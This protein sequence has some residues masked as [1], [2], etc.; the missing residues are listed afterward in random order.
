MQIKHAPIEQ[1][2]IELTN[3]CNFNC[4]F[5]PNEI[6]T[7]KKG[8]MKPD[9]A[10][11]I[12]DEISEI[13]LT[14]KVMFHL[15]GEPLLHPNLLELIQ[16]ANEK[17]IGVI[18]NTNGSK[19][20]DKKLKDIYQPG[21]SSLVISYQTPT[22]ETYELRRAKMDF[23][24]YNSEVKNIIRKKFE[25][26]SD[27]PLE[28]HLLN[29]V[30]ADLL[31]LDEDFYILEN[32]GAAKDIIK[33]WLQFGR[34]IEKEYG[35]KRINHD[36]RMLDGL[37]LKRGFKFEIVKDVFLVS[38]KLTTWANTMIKNKKIIPGF[39]G[40]CDGLLDQFGILWDGSCVLCCI[41]YDGKTTVGNVNESDLE[42]IWLSN[43]VEKIRRNLKRN[44]LIHPYCRLC[45][46][47]PNIRSWLYRQLGSIVIY[48][49][50]RSYIYSK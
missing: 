23:Q 1:V 8:F 2:Y 46:G 41:D 11:K 18:L 38:R 14:K 4:A 40:T 32:N 47:G 21:I 19:L 34:E 22:R 50:R 24:T 12:L 39:L 37:S 43:D 42:K 25:Y 31:G 16:Y 6:M 45:R 48:K 20:D 26:N 35:I 33:Q 44:I 49:L 30:D 27:V 3:V 7:R 9:L 5:C 36:R 28:L 15:M 29:S 17:D 13:N 10:K